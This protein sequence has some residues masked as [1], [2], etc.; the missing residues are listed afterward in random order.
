MIFS[1][2]D[3]NGEFGRVI[4][5]AKGNDGKLRGAKLRLISNKVTQTTAH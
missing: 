4:S 5:L 1:Y 3:R 2:R